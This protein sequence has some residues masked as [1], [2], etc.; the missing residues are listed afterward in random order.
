M[1]K[2]NPRKYIIATL[3]CKKNYQNIFARTGFIKVL[4][5]SPWPTSVPP[6]DNKIAKTGKRIFYLLKLALVSF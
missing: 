6:K 2:F 1:R 3:Y 4:R 5:L